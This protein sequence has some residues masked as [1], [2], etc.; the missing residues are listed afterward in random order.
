MLEGSRVSETHVERE[1]ELV[2]LRGCLCCENGLLGGFKSLYFAKLQTFSQTLVTRLTEAVL[3]PAAATRAPPHTD[4][5]HTLLENSSV[6]N[7]S[8]QTIFQRSDSGL[9]DVYTKKKTT[10]EKCVCWCLL[11]CL[12]IYSFVYLLFGSGS[13]NYS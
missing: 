6:L 3:S 9:P 12:F 2:F 1:Q 13:I 8:Y 7:N 4:P 11:A 10:G 5:D